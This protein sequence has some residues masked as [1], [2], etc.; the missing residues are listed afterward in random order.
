M[1]G[2][3]TSSIELSVV[4]CTRDRPELLR[5]AVAAVAAQTHPGVVETI[6]VFD[7]SEPDRSLASDDPFRPVRVYANER[8]PGLPGGRN[9]GVAHAGAPMVAFCDD[10]DVWFP[11]KA[12]KQLALLAVNPE[13]EV[14][15]TGIRVHADGQ[16][17]DRVW[18]GRT[19]QFGD[20]LASRVMEAHPSTVMVRRTAMLEGIG[21]VD[22]VI[23]GGYAED[24]EWLLRAARRAPIVVLQE[25]L[26]RVDWH[27]KSFFTAQWVTI[28]D[29]LAYL[30][31][32]YP[33]FA[34][35]R[36]GCARIRGQ[37]AFALAAVGRRREAWREIGR[38][39]AL[40]PREPRA[41]LAVLVASGAVSAD[42]VVR[43]V[44]RRG[45]G[46]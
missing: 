29:A 15:V 20:L 46:I 45:R 3:A 40:S 36:G 44:N 16:Q 19:V 39:V 26:V 9:T 13:A 21:P 23:P 33:E 38:T 24:Y 27:P 22:E 18:G 6:V 43:A 35:D 10:D 17:T 42:R 37:R 25:P 14:A 8:T 11:D 7:R 4:I 31:A 2:V 41:H 30:L 28:A 5:R 1:D 12:S 34:T 32:A